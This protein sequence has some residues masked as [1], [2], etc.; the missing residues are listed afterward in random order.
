MEASAHLQIISGAGTGTIR[1]LDLP[2]LVLGR[3]FDCDIPIDS[4]DVSRRHAEILRIQDEVLPGRPAQHQRHLPERPAGSRPTEDRRRRPD[5]R[6]RRDLR[7]SL[8]CFVPGL[9]SRQCGSAAGRGT[10]RT[11]TPALSRKSRRTSSPSSSRRTRRAFALVL[12]RRR[13]WTRSGPRPVVRPK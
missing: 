11:F 2:A 10:R 12:S 6:Q 4:L 8:R 1:E 5:S 13:R 9:A 7:V 3:N